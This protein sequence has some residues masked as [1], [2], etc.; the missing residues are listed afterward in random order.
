M[1]L[2]E[3]WNVIVEQHNKNLHAT[4]AV[5]QG[6]W[7]KIFAEIFGYS[8]LAGEI[9]SQRT[10]RIGSTDRATADII[11][12]SGGT[13]LFVVELKR[14]N[15][16]FDRGAEEQLFSYL[17]LTGNNI[18]VLICDKIYVY[19]CDFTKPDNEQDRAEI[20]FDKDI[21]DGVKFV[22]MF[23]K[24]TFGADAIK[25]FIYQKSQSVKNIAIIKQ[26]ITS[27][28]VVD[29]LRNHF[30]KK[31]TGF[32][33]DEVV[34]DFKIIVTQKDTPSLPITS[35]RP[36]YRPTSN[37]VGNNKTISRKQAIEICRQNGV[38]ITGKT[39]YANRVDYRH[40]YNIDPPVELLDEDWWLLLIDPINSKIHIFKIPANSLPRDQVRFRKSGPPKF[41]LH[42]RCD[43]I[44]FED[45]GSGIK[46]APFHVKT[47]NY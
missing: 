44:A 19:A 21:S 38:G 30:S 28:L 36:I 16:T 10:L 46:F 4:E 1:T 37:V 12:K 8:S 43:N 39:R 11:I 14:H 3:K 23:S 15:T 2:A 25:E 24:A 40:T 13:D 31:F 33:F 22:E 5:V 27:E 20:P 32:D 18:G 26:E 6:I 17:K 34:N 47:I 41:H 9:D 45:V 35:Y 29:L 42:I 7:E